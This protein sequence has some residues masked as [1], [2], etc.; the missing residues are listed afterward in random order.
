MGTP[1]VEVE[2]EVEVEREKE[3]KDFN[4]AFEQIW[5]KYPNKAGKSK[6][7]EKFCRSV[8]TSSDL[9]AIHDALNRYLQHLKA[10]TWKQ[11]QDGKTWFNNWRDWIYFQEVKKDGNIDVSKFF[12]QSI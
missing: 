5:K 7:Y 3:Q 2:V 1:E 11:P 8:K 10:N 6:A 9:K 12:E 4:L